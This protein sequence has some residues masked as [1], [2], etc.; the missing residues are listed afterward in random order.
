MLRPP[1]AVPIYFLATGAE[2][3]MPFPNHGGHVTGVLQNRR[4]RVASRL[5]DER[6]ITQQNS[7][8]RL[9]K[10]VFAGENGKPRR[11]AGG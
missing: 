7:R 9:A 1:I 8:A 3:E 5:D 6:G 2:T 11:R 10:G 4:Q